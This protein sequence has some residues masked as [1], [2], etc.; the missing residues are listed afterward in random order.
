M[1]KLPYLQVYMEFPLTFEHY[2]KQL[3]NPPQPVALS[4]APSIRSFKV[5]AECPLIGEWS[6]RI[7]QCAVRAWLHLNGTSCWT[8]SA[9]VSSSGRVPA[10]ASPSPSLWLGSLCL[11]PDF[12][13]ADGCCTELVLRLHLRKMVSSAS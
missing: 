7:S 11:M 13:A 5:V 1:L 4:Y 3:A 6:R 10:A 2:F 9:I 12:A 8:G